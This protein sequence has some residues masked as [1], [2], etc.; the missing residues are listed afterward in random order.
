MNREEK[1]TNKIIVGSKPI[2]VYIPAAFFAFEQY[3]EIIL[4]GMGSNINKLE[5]MVKMF[6]RF[7]VKETQRKI[8]DLRDSK[9]TVVTLKRGVIIESK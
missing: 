8:E 6:S 7:G 4:S 9:I 2:T 3:D 5:R 1:G